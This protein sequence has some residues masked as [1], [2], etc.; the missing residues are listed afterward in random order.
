MLHVYDIHFFFPLLGVSVTRGVKGRD[1][2]VSVKG[3]DLEVKV[4]YS[5]IPPLS[6][7]TS[8]GRGPFPLK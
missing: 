1:L 7:I 8:K 3:R 4:V 5:I 2:E 6:H